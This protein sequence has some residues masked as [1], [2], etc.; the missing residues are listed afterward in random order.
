MRTILLA[1]PSNLLTLPSKLRRSYA[2]ESRIVFW[3]LLFTMLVS[4]LLLI[5]YL[6]KILEF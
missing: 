4:S 2:L 6:R 5:F 1:L 3:N